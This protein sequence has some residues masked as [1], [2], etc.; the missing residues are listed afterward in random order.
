V[1]CRHQ[2]TLKHIRHTAADMSWAPKSYELED[3]LSRLEVCCTSLGDDVAR[4]NRRIV[5]LQAQLDHFFAKADGM[6]FCPT[7]YQVSAR[8][9][10]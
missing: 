7:E 2:S 5:A 10:K 8:A 6:A 4:L 1:S 3:R 9:D